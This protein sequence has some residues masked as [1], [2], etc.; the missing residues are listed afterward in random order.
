MMNFS[1]DRAFDW[2]IVICAGQWD[3]LF[4]A[5]KGIDNEAL[6]SRWNDLVVLREQK[7]SG[8]MNAFCIGK[9]IEVAWDLHG[10]RP[11]KEPKIPPAV[12]S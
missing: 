4:L 12:V 10:D 7:N 9:T 1:H 5:G 3:Y 11:G 2:R 6:R 8:Y